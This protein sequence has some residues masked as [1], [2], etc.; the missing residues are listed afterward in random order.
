[1]TVLRPLAVPAA[2]IVLV[3]V[4]PSADARPRRPVDDV[5]ATSPQ[6]TLQ[7]AVSGRKAPTRVLPVHT[8]TTLPVVVRATPGEA[9]VPG[10]CY[11]AAVELTGAAA[12]GRP[13]TATARGPPR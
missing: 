4:T 13:I 9:A 2:A 12:A 10:G 5:W 8:A 11:P 3:T 6:P 1:M 7:T